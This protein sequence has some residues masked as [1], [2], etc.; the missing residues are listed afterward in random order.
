MIEGKHRLT[1]R[2]YKH[3]YFDRVAIYQHARQKRLQLKMMTNASRCQPISFVHND[4]SNLNETYNIENSSLSSNSFTNCIPSER[5]SY[6]GVVGLGVYTQTCLDS[7]HLSLI[8]DFV[9]KNYFF[10]KLFCLSSNKSSMLELDNS[11]SINQ[12]IFVL[13]T[14]NEEFCQ[15]RLSTNDQSNKL[16]ARNKLV[17]IKH[18]LKDTHMNKASKINFPKP[19]SNNE[20]TKAPQTDCLSQNRFKTTDKLMDELKKTLREKFGNLK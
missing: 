18:Y 2:T 1:F 19:I 8:L 7:S 15:S 11:N 6:C 3:F 16:E 9:R 5:D 14:V 13:K 10:F 17:K 4:N 12:D 20:S